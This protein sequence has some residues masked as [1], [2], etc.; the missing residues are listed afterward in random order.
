MIRRAVVFS[1][2]L[3]LVIVGCAPI[4]R[5]FIEFETPATSPDASQAPVVTPVPT[6][7]PTPVPVTP[8]PT[9]TPTAAPTVAPTPVPT[10]EPTLNISGIEV[11]EVTSTSATITWTCSEYANAWMEWGAEGSVVP[12]VSYPETNY[13]GETSLVYATHIQ[14]VSGLE[15]ETTYHFRVFCLVPDPA[16]GEP[17]IA[18]VPVG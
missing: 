12:D 8:A 10:A 11:L 7:A 5:I 9:S 15:P 13:P 18:M 1:V 2:L 4:T 17:L 16:G 6:L 14:T 3:A